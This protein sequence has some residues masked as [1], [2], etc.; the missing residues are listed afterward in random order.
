[1]GGCWALVG[2]GAVAFRGWVLGSRRRW[3][4]WCSALVAVGESVLGPRRFSS[5]MTLGPRRC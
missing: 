3:W 1:M 5:V 4:L 2:R